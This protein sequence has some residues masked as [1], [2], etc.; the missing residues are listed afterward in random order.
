MFKRNVLVKIVFLASMIFVLSACGKTS[1]ITITYNTNGG[2][3]IDN[4]VIE[5]SNSIPIPINPHKD[6]F[7][8]EGW[9]S[10]DN[11]TQACDFNSIPTENTTIYAKWTP[12]QESVTYNIIYNLNGG[13]NGSSNPI[14][15]SS[16]MT[17]LVLSDPVR[18]GY[19]FAGW[20][21]DSTFETIFN[22][23]HL[24]SSNLVLYA[25]WIE[26]T[27]DENSLTIM[28]LPIHSSLYGNTNGNLNNKG[29]AVY[30]KTLCLHYYSSGNTV[31]SYDPS[32]EVTEVVFSLSTG[33][34]ATY[35]NLD[36]EILY[37]IDSSNGYLMSY[38]LVNNV[39]LT[40]EESLNT[41]A[42]TTQNWVNIIHEVELY[43]STYVS[44]QRYNKDNGTFS[45]YTNGIEY[46]NIDGTRVYYKPTGQIQLSMMSYNG[47]GK[48]PIAYLSELNVEI[49]NEMLLLEVD[50]DYIPYYALILT[51]NGDLG[52]YTYDSTNGLSKIAE[53]IGGSLHSLNYDGI[54]L[55]Y[56]AKDGLYR[57][58][59]ESSQSEK[60]IDLPGSNSSIQIINHWIY[61]STFQENNIYRINPET[62]LIDL[63]N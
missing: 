40:I 19:T 50:N 43:G 31:Y 6:G 3:K 41:Y 35:L 51:V 9:Y 22:T 54:N 14:S 45:T 52:L 61:V 53:D 39:K 55:Y 29:L 37:Y 46:M 20:H 4:A 1:E 15:F 21:I 28:T 10:D 11:F 2:T 30:N 58:K 5:E 57:Y 62:N 36:K 26:D 33:G 13:T 25:K 42:S 17:S 47:M 27:I 56:I 38:D 44:L 59:L 18:D 24:P 48:S 12:I 32:T 16:D 49:I 8:F 60:V 34:R 23:N 63:L 7:S